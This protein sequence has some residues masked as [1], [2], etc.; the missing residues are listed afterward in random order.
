MPEMRRRGLLIILSSPSGAGKS[1]L[2]RR[3]MAWDAS[4]SFSVSATTRNPRPGEE[5]GREYYFR[6]RPEFEAMVAAGEMLEHAE[7]FGNLYGTPSAPVEAR[8]AE[9]RDVILDI[10][11][12]GGQQVR[13][14]R[15]AQDVV[16]IFILPPSIADLER[17]LRMRAQDSDE[18]IA[19]RMAKSRDEIS[20][21]GE[22][23]YVV[24]NRDIAASEAE[25][26]TI[27]QAER[28]RAVRQPGLTEF[29]RG[30]NREFEAR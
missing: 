18:V 12:Q 22:Y 21:W 26:V 11:W 30:L 10:D 19:G 14:S 6:S 2:A 25:L 13:R 16:S 28:A 1:T 20:H 7:V 24:I 8:L 15:L 23:D 27:L 4:L 3:L 5:D 29:V 17:R 9:G